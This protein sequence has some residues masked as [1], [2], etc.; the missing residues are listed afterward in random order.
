VTDNEKDAPKA[1]EA[2]QDATELSDAD[3]GDVAGGINPQPL[4]P[5]ARD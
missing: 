2:E 5:F 1:Q 4:P 3:L